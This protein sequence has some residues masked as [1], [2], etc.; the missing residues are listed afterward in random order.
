MLIVRYAFK[1]L[2]VR[3]A[4]KVL[5]VRYAFKVLIVRYAFKVLIVRRILSVYPVTTCEKV[6][7]SRIFTE[8]DRKTAKEAPDGKETRTFTEDKMD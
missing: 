2:I 5:I 1:V 7:I 6:F 8:K 4:F 3:Y